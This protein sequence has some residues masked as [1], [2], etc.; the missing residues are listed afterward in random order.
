VDGPKLSYEEHVERCLELLR[1]GG[2]L[3]VDNALMSGAVAG[4]GG[5]WSPEQVES[6]RA[7]NARLMK[8]ARLDATITAVGDGVALAVRR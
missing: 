7:L 3:V 6:Q 1:P 4:S 2:L 5:G 8:D